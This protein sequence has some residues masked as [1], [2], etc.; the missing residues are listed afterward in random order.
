M[1]KRDC[2]TY[3]A[4]TKALISFAVTAKLICI[5][6]FAYAKSQFSHDAA[7]SDAKKVPGSAGK[8]KYRYHVMYEL[9][10]IRKHLFKHLGK[11]K[12]QNSATTS[13]CR[14]LQLTATLSVED[15][16]P[17][18]GRGIPFY[19]SQFVSILGNLYPDRGVKGPFLGMFGKM[20][21]CKKILIQAYTSFI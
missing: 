3:V 17:F 14:C 9:W 16:P 1:K 15:S 2:T 19:L 8:M 10:S 5:F 20:D 7:L 13:L 4:K 12:S 18:R 6:V 21:L 11:S